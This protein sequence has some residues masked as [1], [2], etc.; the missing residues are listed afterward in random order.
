MNSLFINL[1]KDSS[2]TEEE[3]KIILSIIQAMEDIKSARRC[4]EMARD[5]RLVDYAIYSEEAAKAKYMYFLVQ[6][7]NKNI[8]INYNYM[9]KELNIV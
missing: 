7:R 6:A 8:K 5:P 1:K 2:Y 3:K 9:I 4:F